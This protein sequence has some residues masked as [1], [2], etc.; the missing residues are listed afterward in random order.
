MIQPDCNPS[1]T[2]ESG[3]ALF[4]ILA[5]GLFYQWHLDSVVGTDPR[6]PLHALPGKTVN[7]FRLNTSNYP[8]TFYIH[9]WHTNTF[10]L[11]LG[12]LVMCWGTVIT[13]TLLCECG[14]FFFY[15][16]GPPW[17]S[18]YFNISLALPNH[19]GLWRENNINLRSLSAVGNSLELNSENNALSLSCREMRGHVILCCQ[20]GKRQNVIYSTL[21]YISIQRK[22]NTSKV[23]YSKHRHVIHLL[24]LA[25]AGQWE[26]QDLLCKKSVAYF[27]V[28]CKLLKDVIVKA[29]C[30]TGFNFSHHHKLLFSQT[31]HYSWTI[32][33]HKKVFSGNTYN[34]MLLMAKI[35]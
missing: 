17:N 25:V 15:L 2:W 19:S 22:G 18:T 29:K 6:I 3:P 31:N 9:L 34:W 28:C 24:Y 16:L 14:F 35:W 11:V 21:K 33:I 10:I 8:F 7:V 26:G 1:G 30:W 13:V 27:H 32:R 5:G 23:L 4:V 12:P 20:L